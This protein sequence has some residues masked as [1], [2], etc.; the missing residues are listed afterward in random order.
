MTPS[1]KKHIPRYK[2][3]FALLFRAVTFIY[4]TLARFT[5]YN[6]QCVFIIL[7]LAMLLRLPFIAHPDHTQ[8]DEVIYTSY[9]LHMIA[10]LPYFDIHP[11]LA[12]IVFAAIAGAQ[13]PFVTKT[14]TMDFAQPFGD[15]PYIAIRTFIA[16]MGI[17]LPL[18][19]YYIGR[20]LGY[21][22]RVAMLPALFVV[23]DSALVIYS[24]VILPDMLLLV[25]NFTAFMT[26]LAATKV[27]NEKHARYLI[28]GSGIALGLALSIKWTALGILLTMWALFIAT[29]RFKEIFITG[30]IAALVYIAV[31]VSFFMY[32]P[33]GGFAD[34]PTSSLDRPWVHEIKFPNTRSLPDVLR[35]LPA[36]HQAMLYAGKDPDVLKETMSAPNPL[37]WPVAKSALIFWFDQ[38]NTI[39][40]MGNSVLWVLVF[41][42]FLF[43]LGWTAAMYKTI[44]KLPI[45]KDELILLAGYAFNYLPFFLIHRPM[46]VY[47]Y[48]TALL[49]LFLLVPKVAPRIL[50]CLSVLSRD[51][52]FAY[53]FMTV[54]LMSIFLNFVLTMPITYGY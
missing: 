4:D 35:A 40:L 38:N 12:K 25:C 5:A 54:A 52:L 34:S 6:Y 7:F 18:I 29:R 28:V 39:V 2:Q 36:Y 21:K 30:A 46:Y 17:L 26:A 33:Q 51:R 41:F 1:A 24:R 23:F 47:H 3:Y 15:F 9:T 16:Y 50:N 37:S 42:V 8:F 13:T 31:F 20:L 10:G 27:K 14:I 22:P 48:F 19:V 11:P 32:F 53:T 44:H 49:F 43:D 45:A